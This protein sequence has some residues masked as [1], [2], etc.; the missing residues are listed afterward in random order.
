MTD[1]SNDRRTRRT[2]GSTHGIGAAF[3][4][5]SPTSLVDSRVPGTHADPSALL[6]WIDDDGASAGLSR[7]TTPMAALASSLEIVTQGFH[8]LSDA[9]ADSL[10]DLRQQLSGVDPP[11][12]SESLFLGVLRTGLAAA[13]SGASEFVAAAIADG[14]LREFVKTAIESGVSDGVAAGGATLAGASKSSAIAAF[15]SSQREGARRAFQVAQGHW[16]K[17]GRHHVHTPQQ[18][19]MLEAAFSPERMKIAGSRQ[20]NASRDAWLTYLAQTKFGTVNSRRLDEGGEVVEVGRTTD[21]SSEKDRDDSSLAPNAVT[22][23][24]GAAPGVLSIRV[25]LPSLQPL[26]GTRMYGMVGMPRVIAAYLNGTNDAIRQQYV[27]QP[28]STVKI[29]RTLTCET[30]DGH[31]PFVV[32]VNEAGV[33]FGDAN[34]RWLR[35]RA[36]VGRPQDLGDDPV[37]LAG[38]GLDLLLAEIVPMRIVKGTSE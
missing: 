37:T 3:W 19:Q 7:E 11:T 21:L 4:S 24:L 36:T 34:N 9:A 22:A 17:S 33:V 26:G 1:A 14:V 27:G 31:S 25:A 18:A 12:F 30:A 32:S 15:I 16:I 8:W 13:T 28:M 29:P 5:G 10:D 35:D 38:R 2:E 6:P 20:R 23:M